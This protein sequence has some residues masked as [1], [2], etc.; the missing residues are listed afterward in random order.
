MRKFRKVR[1]KEYEINAIK[2]TA[3]EVFGEKTRVILFGSRVDL[4]KRGGDIDLYIIPEKK[5]NLFE[6]ELKFKSK[7]QLKIGERKIDVV[8]SKNPERAIEK[9]AVENGVEL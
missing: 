2:E 3:K 5:D 4:T 9:V 7:L 6:R 1:L 8:I